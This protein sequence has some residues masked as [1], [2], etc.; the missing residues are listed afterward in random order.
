MLYAS[1]IWIR[2][3][4]AL[5]CHFVSCFPLLRGRGTRHTSFSHLAPSLSL[6]ERF[7]LLFML[8]IQNSVFLLA[9]LLESGSR[10]TFRGPIQDVWRREMRNS[11]FSFFFSLALLSTCLFVC[12]GSS[13]SSKEDLKSRPLSGSIH[14]R[15]Y[16]LG[17]MRR[18]MKLRVV[19]QSNR[20]VCSVFFKF[21]S[22]WCFFRF[23]LP[24]RA[25]RNM[26][27]PWKVL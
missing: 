7:M 1:L 10:F 9:C 23:I 14:W 26:Q 24:K 27:P 12:G 4:L 15:L 22:N 20:R 17:E 13:C 25:L 8:F 6:V 18:E 19:I 11:S 3:S 16:V 5:S 2:L 21:P